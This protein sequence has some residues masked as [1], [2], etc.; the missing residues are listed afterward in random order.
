MGILSG[1]CE[2]IVWPF[3]EG[4]KAAGKG[5]GRHCEPMG[6]RVDSNYN[7]WVDG[8]RGAISKIGL[9]ASWQRLWSK[10]I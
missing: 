8:R 1:I 5:K 6:A 4:K 7:E 2:R 9:A 3:S 10:N